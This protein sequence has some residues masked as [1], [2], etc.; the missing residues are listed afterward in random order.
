MNVKKVIKSKMPKRL[1]Q[2]YH[3]YNM[4][5]L[6]TKSFKYDKKRYLKYAT[7][8][9]SSIKENIY[10]SLIFHT[11]SIEKG[12]SHPKFR[13]GFG[14]GALRGIKSSLDEL[15]KNNYSKDSFEY[16]N[17]ISVLKAY[18][19]RHIKLKK[20]TPFF[21]NLF[22]Q[23]LYK[24][25]NNMAGSEDKRFVAKNDYTYKELIKSRRSVREFSD[26][27]VSL[28][29]VKDCV[30]QAIT[31]PSVCNRQPWKIYLTDNQT[32]IKQLLALQGGFTGYKLPPVLALVTTDLHCFRGYG[33]RNEGYVDGGLFLMN[34]LLSLADSNLAACTL[35]AM[36]SNEILSSMCSLLRVSSSELPIA[37][38]VIGHYSKDYRVASSARKSVDDI[39]MVRND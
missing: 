29:L 36:Q 38:V 32:K 35:N 33:E 20:A 3:Y 4:R 13:A 22:P 31:T 21:D 27:S 16:K 7:F 25:A 18:K 34:F 24:D 30:A 8:D 23:K 10:S 37:F 5:R 26:D 14:K 17:A 19:E 15:E 6:V 11:H 28:K 2:K 9:A 12:L 39:C 1:Y